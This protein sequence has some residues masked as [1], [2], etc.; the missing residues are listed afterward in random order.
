MTHKLIPAPCPFCGHELMASG[1]MLRHAV[2]SKC[3]LKGMFIENDPRGVAGWN[4]RA[5]AIPQRHPSMMELLQGAADGRVDGS[6]RLVVHRYSGRG[7]HNRHRSWLVTLNCIL[8]GG[9]IWVMVA[10]AGAIGKTI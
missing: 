8:I 4:R 9:R 10:A 1:Q 2:G 5:P 3:L 6:R 7:H